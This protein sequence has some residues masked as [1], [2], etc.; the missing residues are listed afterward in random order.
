MATAHNPDEK[1]ELEAVQNELD[2]AKKSTE[3]RFEK[4]DDLTSRFRELRRKNHFR[5]MLE[6]LFSN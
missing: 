2:K 3:A 5:L 4:V 1:R 6:D